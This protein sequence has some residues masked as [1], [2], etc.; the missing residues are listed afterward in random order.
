MNRDLV[1]AKIAK[2]L[3]VAAIAA[4]AV[5][6]G[7]LSSASLAGAQTT[8]RTVKATLP[9]SIPPNP[10]FTSSGV[11]GGGAND[12][13]ACT[14]AIVK[15]IDNARASE[16][17][18]GIPGSFN[19]AAFDK[20]T[21]AEQVF[22][23]ADIERTARGLAP[24]AG[25]TAQ[26]DAI[27]QSGAANQTDPSTTLPLQLSTGGQATAWGSNWAEGTANGLG[28][29]YYWMYDDG[30]NSPNV[31]CTQS[32]Q[33]GCWGH[34]KNIVSDWESPGYCSPG[35][36]VNVLMG[37]AEV[38][39]NVTYSPSITEFFVN[40]CGRL[41]TDMVFTWADVQTLVFGT[42]HKKA[43]PSL[44]RAG[45]WLATARGNLYNLG[46]AGFAGSAVTKVLPA[47]IV[48]VAPAP[49]G[50]GYWLVT[51]KGN[52]YNFGTARFY[53][54]EALQ[55]LPAPIVGMASTPD[56]RGYWLVSSAG[57]VYNFGDARFYGSEAEKV[58]PAPII[59]LA[60]TEDGGGYWLASSAGN[61][62]HFG[63]ASFHGSEAG[64]TLPAPIVGISARP[65]GGGY[66]LVS[67]AGNV[68][69][70]GEAGFFGSE[71]GLLMPAPVVGLSP[72]PNGHGYWLVSSKGNAYNFGD[73]A[74]SGSEAGK[75]LPSPVVGFAPA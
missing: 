38:T 12:S 42:V 3:S 9:K 31:D 25:M 75:T 7:S 71:A 32:N 48:G 56:G 21:P 61:V 41:P 17:V 45:Y 5:G 15:A 27:A 44:K 55:T 53:G 26:L 37:A 20:L 69:N 34:R 29:D 59:G 13:A 8:P 74:F 51:A 66:W 1:L 6:T 52:V 65:T 62:F 14:T 43:G 70:L 63:D 16:P 4:L 24:M 39:R 54:S 40:D 50:R 73:A 72:T 10:D 57:N 60:P 2:S 67:S 68:Y 22:A 33:Q 58:I 47:S 36:S 23:V 49:A 19:V 46:T 28:A 64:K 11:C 18:L 30:L 35:S